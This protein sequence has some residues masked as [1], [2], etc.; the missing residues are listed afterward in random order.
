MKIIHF[1]HFDSDPRFPPFLLFARCKSGVTFVRRCF[2]DENS[3]RSCIS[4]LSN[5]DEQPL[6]NHQGWSELKC[7][8]LQTGL[9]DL[10]NT[11]L[12]KCVRQIFTF[13][14]K[15][16]AFSRILKNH[17]KHTLKSLNAFFFFLYLNML[18]QTQQNLTS[19][20]CDDCC[21]LPVSM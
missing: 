3:L 17:Q 13:K 1:Y 11:K 2:R 10:K 19:S 9:T 5:Y 14:K 21:S 18:S 15:N 12:L 8:W 7:N 16:I 4:K 6:E 20:F